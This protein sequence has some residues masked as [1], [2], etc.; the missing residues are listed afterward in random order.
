[1]ARV[2]TLTSERDS[3]TARILELEDDYT[4]MVNDYRRD[5]VRM[6]ATIDQLTLR[7]Q[8]SQGRIQRAT[9]LIATCLRSLADLVA[10]R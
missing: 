1:M 5:L 6:Q 2:E 7:D 10:S 8:T 3:A 4:G 9:A